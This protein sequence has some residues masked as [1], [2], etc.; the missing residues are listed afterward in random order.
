MKVKLLFLFLFF[1]VK[2]VSQTKVNIKQI[3]NTNQIAC[4]KRGVNLKQIKFITKENQL[5]YCVYL[6]GE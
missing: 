5:V 4:K 6:P 1:V 2:I 3:K